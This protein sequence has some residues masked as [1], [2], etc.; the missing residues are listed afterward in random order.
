[1]SYLK[2]FEDYIPL[3]SK[4]DFDEMPDQE[5]TR[6][7]YG[8]NISDPES[9]S[10]YTEDRWEKF[11]KKETDLIL[12]ILQPKR[13]N[14]GS[15]YKKGCFFSFSNLTQT[16]TILK[17]K[18]NWFIVRYS[19]AL[20]GN[21]ID[22]KYKCDTWIGLMKCLK[23][24]QRQHIKLFQK[25]YSKQFQKQFEGIDHSQYFEEISAGEYYIL[26]S[27]LMNNAEDQQI[28]METKWI[29]FTDKELKSIKSFFKPNKHPSD[30]K[31][32][33]YNCRIRFYKPGGG[34]INITKLSDDSY[35]IN[36]MG[37]M[38]DS[39]NENTHFFKC[40]SWNGFIVCL[41]YL[42]KNMSKDAPYHKRLFK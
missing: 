22:R 13:T 28:H 25:V 34:N 6:A 19:G 33:F 9:I 42:R 7:T 17:L 37:K 41:K 4:T 23:S 15:Q 35:L 1:M 24:L 8:D 18:D 16:L 40:D 2:T 32:K 14:I 31:S 11:S 27:G 38:E 39:D 29:D 21:Y 12:K 5:F 26:F 3:T 30:R 10:K 36:L 20:D